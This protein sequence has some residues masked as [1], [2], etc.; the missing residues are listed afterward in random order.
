MKKTDRKANYPISDFILH[1][2]SPRAMSGESLSDEELLPLF[3]AAR[4]APSSYNS[5]PWR[6]VYAKRETPHFARFM[7]LLIDFNKSWC[8]HA[9][10][11]VIVI[12][13][14]TFE[15]NDKPS[16]THSFDTG[17]AWENLAIEGR[18]RGL[19]VHGMSGFDF[20]KA[21][22]TLALPDNYQ[23]ECMLAIGKPGPLDKLP[24][25]IADKETPSDRKP[26]ET[27][28]MEGNFRE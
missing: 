18:G 17:A 22:K 25:E 20:D 9:A 7:D 11:L 23:V 5:Q 12:S 14:K 27:I 1:R 26:L 10:A 21:A 15:H 16:V 13:R 3:E 24:K 8:Q 19:V 28:A 6:F 4:W 2:W